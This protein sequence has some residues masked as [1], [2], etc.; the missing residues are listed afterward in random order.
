MDINN[1][2]G[3]GFINEFNENLYRVESSYEFEVS[4]LPSRIEVETRYNLT[5]LEA[6]ADII[7]Y[8]NPVTNSLLS[9][10]TRPLLSGESSSSLNNARSNI[11]LYSLEDLIE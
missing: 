1:A 11:T 7:K 2:I 8:Y 4:P 10:V 6:D 9:T 3:Q 5:T